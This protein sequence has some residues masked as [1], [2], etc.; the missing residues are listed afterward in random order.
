VIRGSINNLN[1]EII[2]DGEEPKPE[3]DQAIV[4]PDEVAPGNGAPD[5]TA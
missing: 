4:A 2:M 5:V 1:K 3:A